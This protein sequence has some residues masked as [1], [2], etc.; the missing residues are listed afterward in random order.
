[1]QDSIEEALSIFWSHNLAEVLC[2]LTAAEEVGESGDE[3]LAR[4]VGRLQP[5]HRIHTVI[6]C[7][8]ENPRTKNKG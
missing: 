1:M 8:A 2:P 3:A 7:I 4:M 6:F 5:L